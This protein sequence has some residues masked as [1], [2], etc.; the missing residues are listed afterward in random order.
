MAK[1]H[2]KNLLEDP[3]KQCTHWYD[4]SLTRRRI[5]RICTWNGARPK[6]K[7]GISYCIWDGEKLTNV[8]A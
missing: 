1:P 3:G 6:G 8:G 2:R 7:P 5:Q 4:Y